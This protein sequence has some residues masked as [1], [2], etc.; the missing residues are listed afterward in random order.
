MGKASFLS[1]LRPLEWTENSFQSSV[2]KGT[3]D[4]QDLC[5]RNVRNSHPSDGVLLSFLHPP[6]LEHTAEPSKRPWTGLTLLT[7]LS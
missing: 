4:L 6:G 5:P 2:I 3:F 1:T 7:R